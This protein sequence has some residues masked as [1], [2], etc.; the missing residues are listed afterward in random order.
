MDASKWKL[1]KLLILVIYLA[2]LI[3]LEQVFRSPMF[4]S[5]LTFELDWQ[6]SSPGSQSFWIFCS[7]LGTGP[8]LIPMLAITYLFFP[9]NKAYSYLTV[10]I[11][12]YYLDNIMKLWYGNPR[13]FWLN[14]ELF[15]ACN[16]GFGNPSGHSFSSAS[17]YFAFFHIVT[18]FDWFKKRL[19]GVITRV[20]L[21]IL[22]FVIVVLIVLSRLY[23]GAHSTNQILYGGL[24]GLG[25]YYFVFFVMEWSSQTPEEFSQFFT[26]KKIT[27]IFIIK[28]ILL[29]LAC[30]L[31]YGLIDNGEGIYS[32]T[33]D[34][35]CPDH[36]PYRKF[37]PDAVFGMLSLFGIIGGHF[38]LVFLFH[39]TE[40][41]YTGKVN[42]VVYWYKGTCKSH[43]LRI[44][45]CIL[46]GLPLIL[47][48][49]ISGKSSLV[50]I[51]V[52]KV[53][54]PYL[55]ALFGLFGPAVFFSIKLRL[56]NPDIY[57]GYASTNQNPSSSELDSVRLKVPS[58]NNVKV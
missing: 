2:L 12:G 34:A 35:L 19:V 32:P 46:F 5:S 1:I 33:L 43:I 36:N 54:V 21:G 41:S 18:D 6:K 10:M 28:Y 16:G 31:S 15:K 50:M 53:S 30:F 51:F 27:I 44:M 39:L 17:A 8:V 9:L 42:A 3:G 22:T 13:P 56:A 4:E 52:F 20:L 14:P 57:M 47:I 24:L 58:N 7:E 48:F 11:Y 25:L 55:V 37:N 23:L 29:N 26:Q 45:L 40:K 38:G 49:I